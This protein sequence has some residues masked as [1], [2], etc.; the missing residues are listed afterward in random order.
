MNAPRII[1]NYII[2]NGEESDF[3]WSGKLYAITPVILLKR[4]EWSIP[5][6]VSEIPELP[7]ELK[8]KIEALERRDLVCCD[9]HDCQH[10]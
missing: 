9:F 2:P 8:K 5:I 4:L 3:F 10:K 1:P 7:Q 6:E